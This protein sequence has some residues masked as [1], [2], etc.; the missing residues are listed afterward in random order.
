MTHQSAHLAA[1]ADPLTERLSAEL[2][3]PE[4]QVEGLG[5]SM[6]SEMPSLQLD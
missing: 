3:L 6:L 4:V 5:A 1:L 2:E